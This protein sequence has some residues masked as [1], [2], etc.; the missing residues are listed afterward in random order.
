MANSY[1]TKEFKNLQS[2]WYAKLAKEGFKDQED[3]KENLIQ[4][5][6]RTI[7]FD[8]RDMLRDFFLSLSAYLVHNRV[9]TRDRKILELFS[10][11]IHI[12]GKNGIVEKTGW[13]DKTVRNVIKSYKNKLSTQYR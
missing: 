11:G 12:K 13:S 8:N 6:R 4:Q 9:P 3:A 5:D 10:Q 1:K 2:K 7:A